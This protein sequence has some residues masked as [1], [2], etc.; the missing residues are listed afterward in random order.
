MLAAYLKAYNDAKADA[1]GA[2]MTDDV[3]LTDSDGEVLGWVN[4]CHQTGED[5]VARHYMAERA[6]VVP[7]LIHGD[8]E[9]AG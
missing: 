6:R 1:L 8:A 5:D 7:V 9:L 2:L 3:E 4:I